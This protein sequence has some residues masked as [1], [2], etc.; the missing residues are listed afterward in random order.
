MGIFATLRSKFKF[1]QSIGLMITASHNPSQ[2][3]G[4]KIID[5]NGFMLDLSW[6]SFATKLANIPDD[7]VNDYVNDFIKTFN[8][9]DSINGHVIL[10][11]DTRES[12]L[13]LAKAACD[14]IKCL[15]GDFVDHGLLTTPQL[16]LIVLSKNF[17]GMEPN[18]EGYYSK[19]SSAF[20]SLVRLSLILN[21]N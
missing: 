17:G 7:Q 20:N 19:I 13:R 1:G 6:E 18:E 21:H 14:G 3:N 15:N 11:R 10:G 4:L 12:S 5:S 8:L 16:H 2:Y 9:S